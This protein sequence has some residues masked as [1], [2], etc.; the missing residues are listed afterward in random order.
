LDIPLQKLRYEPPSLDQRIG[1]HPFPRLV[2]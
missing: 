1:G 2:D